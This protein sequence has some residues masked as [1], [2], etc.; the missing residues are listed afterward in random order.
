LPTGTEITVAASNNLLLDLHQVRSAGV[1]FDDRFG[2][3]GGEDTLFTRTIRQRGGRM[4]W[5]NEAFVV[6]VVPAA[7]VSRR[8]VLRRAFSYGNT[9]SR[10]S[11]ALA[12]GSVERMRSRLVLTAEGLARVGAGGVRYAAG[13]VVRSIRWRARGA[14]RLMRGL[15]TVSGAWGHT[16]IAYGHAATANG[17]RGKSGAAA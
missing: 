10:V 3:S 15:G 2:A 9:Y 8:F 13:A 11:I 1:R 6:D 17:S 4:V 14:R 7:R 12:T 16:H 5:C